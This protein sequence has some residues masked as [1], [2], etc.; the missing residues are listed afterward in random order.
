MSGSSLIAGYVGYIS[1]VRRFSPRTCEIYGDCLNRFLSFV[2]PV[3]DGDAQ[4]PEDPDTVLV[5]SLLPEKIRRYEAML[6]NNGISPR[7]V[8]LHVSAI[9]GFCRYLV[10]KGILASN[11]VRLVKKP[12]TGRRLPEFYRESDMRTYFRRTEIFVRHPEDLSPAEFIGHYV[13]SRD[14]GYRESADEVFLHMKGLEADPVRFHEWLYRKRLERIVIATLYSTG[15]RRAELCSL[16]R[17]N[18]DGVRRMLKVRGKGDKTREIPIIPSLYEEIS[19]YLHTVETMVEGGLNGSS[20][21]YVTLKGGPLYPALVDRLVKEG[22]GEETDITG[23]KSPH[24]LRHTVA[25]ELLDSGADINSIKEFLGHSS[26]AATQV[27]TH[28]TVAKLKKIYQTAHPRA[29]IGGK[30]GD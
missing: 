28:N 24:V 11:P 13:A 27:Y 3:A 4:S 21:L 25:T 22:L 19:L 30:N 12:K 15:I 2:M 17:E 10:K 14:R 26:L 20:P 29:K 8:N 23:R 16:R 6:I 18:F 5:R 1:S 9:S 7:T